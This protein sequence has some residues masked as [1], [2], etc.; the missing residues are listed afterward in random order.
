MKEKKKV[1]E[2]NEGVSWV[3]WSRRLK[4]EQAWDIR[5][6]QAFLMREI[7]SIAN[8]LLIGWFYCFPRKVS[9]VKIN[10]E[11]IQIHNLY[12]EKFSSMINREIVQLQNI[13]K[14]ILQNGSVNT[15]IQTSL[16]SKTNTLKHHESQILQFILVTMLNVSWNQ[17]DRSLN[18]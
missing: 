16:K 1:I 5:N 2:V 18:S 3:S 14:S 11:M 12:S 15:W 6:I 13:R 10:I 9:N 17:N 7:D 8:V 4:I